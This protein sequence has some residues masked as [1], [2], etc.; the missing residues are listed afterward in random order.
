VVG[1]LFPHLLYE[2]APAD[3][4]VL[5][6]AAAVIAVAVTAGCLLPARRAAGVDP[7][8]TLRAE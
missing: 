3:P 2:V 5:G 1:Q 7:V 4:R 6:L 8:T